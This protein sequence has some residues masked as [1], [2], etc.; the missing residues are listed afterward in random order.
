PEDAPW[1]TLSHSLACNVRMWDDQ[2]AAFKDR[3]R[4][5]A[6]DTRGHGQSSAP[7]GSYTLK[8]LADDLHGLFAHLGIAR[9]HFVGLSMGGMIGQTFALRF[10]GVFAS[11]TLADTT[12]RYPAEAAEMW[13]GRIRAARS[14]GME[15][16]V[17]P[18]LERWFTEPF[19]KSRPEVIERVGALIASTPVDGYIGCCHAISGIGVTARLKE[20][21]CPMLVIVGEQDAA[22]PPAMAREIHANAPG[23]TLVVLP[24]AAH[25]SNMEQPLAFNRA[26]E[27]FLAPIK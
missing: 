16:I 7:A 6:L 21:A 25:L 2:I 17:R 1:L 22:T 4:V 9:T 15:P 10:P 5:L 8:G 18:T 14:Q 26:L 13:A 23:S 11:L 12:S 20:I 19:R 24:E 27:Q 3:Y